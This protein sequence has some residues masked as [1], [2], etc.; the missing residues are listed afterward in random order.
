MGRPIFNQK[1]LTPNTVASPARGE[2]GTLEIC[3]NLPR[4]R[5]SYEPVPSTL[6]R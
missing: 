5:K 2:G 1:S 6:I 3:S 4:E